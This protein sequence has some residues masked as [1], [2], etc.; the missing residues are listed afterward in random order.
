MVKS[1][2]VALGAAAIATVLAGCG[3]T[4]H[5]ANAPRP[6]ELLNLT[7]AV[8]NGRV[9]VSP[10]RIGAGPVAVIV[11][12]ETQAP[13]QVTLSSA[14]PGVL[15]EQ[16]APINP[17]GTATLRAVIQPGRYSVATQDSTIRGAT[18]HVGAKRAST[19]NTL[20]LP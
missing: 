20:L 16:T 4:S 13:Q 14:Q 10:N 15:R 19:Q 8:A 17:G 7:A 9:V 12:N 11:A 18:I 2:R 1:K 3:S 6:P 5:Y